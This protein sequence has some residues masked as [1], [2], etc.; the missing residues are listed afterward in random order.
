MLPLHRQRV[1]TIRDTC[2]NSVYKLYTLNSLPLL[3]ERFKFLTPCLKMGENMNKAFLI[4]LTFTL[5]FF[6]STSGTVLI[7]IVLFQVIHWTW[8]AQIEI[9]RQKRGQTFVCSD[10]KVFPVGTD[11]IPNISNTKCQRCVC[12]VLQK[13]KNMCKWLCDI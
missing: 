12:L 11:Q 6:F 3:Q 5:F 10:F 2:R 9:K 7:T 8:A 4:T 1:N 13:P